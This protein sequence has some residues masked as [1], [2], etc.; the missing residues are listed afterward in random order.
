[1]SNQSAPQNSGQPL[2]SVEQQKLIDRIIGLGEFGHLEDGFLYWFPSG[3][4]G[5][6]FNE[7]SL[8]AI[9]LYLEMKNNPLDD[10]INEYFDSSNQREK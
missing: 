8:R 5:G 1:M 6:G 7:Y 3:I 4:P 10:S 9:A 2:L